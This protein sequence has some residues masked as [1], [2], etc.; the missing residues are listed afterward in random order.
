MPSAPSPRGEGAGRAAREKREKALLFFDGEEPGGVSSSLAGSFWQ[1][2][3]ETWNITL[4]EYDQAQRALDEAD[5]WIDDVLSLSRDNAEAHGLRIEVLQQR[6]LLAESFLHLEEFR[7]L[8]LRF[9]QL[10]PQEAQRQEFAAM[11]DVELVID[12]PEALDRSQP[13]TWMTEEFAESTLSP[14]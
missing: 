4:E 12:P 10:D 5:T 11:A 6:L 2:A 1:R 13:S 14:R 9:K 3:T 8:M 7:S